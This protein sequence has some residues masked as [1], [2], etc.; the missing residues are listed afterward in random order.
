MKLLPGM[1]MVCGAAASVLKQRRPPLA[2]RSQSKVICFFSRLVSL[3]MFSWLL[4][5]KAC[6]FELFDR[7]VFKRWEMAASTVSSQPWMQKP[8]LNLRQDENEQSRQLTANQV[9]KMECLC[10]SVGG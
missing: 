2:N 5:F 8:I 9:I 3:G 6:S 7:Q 10:P 1:T 4:R